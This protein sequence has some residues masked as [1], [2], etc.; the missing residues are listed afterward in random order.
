MITLIAT[1]MLKS[2]TSFLFGNYLKAHYGSIE[3]DGAPS[4]YGQEP[5][6]AI[7][8]STYNK[9]GLEKLEITKQDSKIKLKK[10]VNHIIE[11]VIYKNFKNL[12]PDEDA[13]LNSIQK[14]KKLPLFIDSNMKFQNIKVDED[15]NMVFV[16]SC[17]DKQAF[18]NYEKKRLKELSTDLTYYKSDKAF[19]ELENKNR[20][21]SGLE[22]KEFDE[23]D[24]SN[25]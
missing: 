22:D 12:T 14:D 8:V 16:R 21:K 11:L 19:N 4:W 24:N 18:L 1:A 6:E 15:K 23:L 13:F 2:L 17:L 20:P 7:C 5:D 10:K 3:I 25:F 9:G